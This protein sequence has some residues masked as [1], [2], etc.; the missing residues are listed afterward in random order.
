MCT[1]SHPY[2]PVPNTVLVQIFYT[3]FGQRLENTLHYYKGGGWA[4]ADLSDLASSVIGFWDTDV[5]ANVSSTVELVGVKITDLTTETAPTFETQPASPLFGTRL[6]EAMPSGNTFAVKTNTGSR[7]RSAHGRLYHIG[8]TT[9]Q[10]TG[11]DLIAVEADHIKDGWAALVFGVA[12]AMSAAPVVTSYCLHNVWR[13]TGVN[14]FI[15]TLS[16][17]DLH[18][19]SQRRRLTGRGQ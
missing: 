17:T 4:P 19:D 8:L 18:V 15:L 14:T 7:G 12:V 3:Q 10:V 9:N 5:K 2:I 11:N 6:D 16:Y 13:T 1:G